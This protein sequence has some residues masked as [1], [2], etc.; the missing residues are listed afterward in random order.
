MRSNHPMLTGLRSRRRAAFEAHRVEARSTGVGRGALVTPRSMVT[1]LHRHQSFW[2][3]QVN[4]V[5]RIALVREVVNVGRARNDRI[6]SKNQT[7][8][9]GNGHDRIESR[10]LREQGPV[11]EILRLADPSEALDTRTERIVERSRTIRELAESTV[12]RVIR[13]RQRIES[14]RDTSVVMRERSSI[15]ADVE[16]A[17]ERTATARAGTEAGRADHAQQHAD[18]QPGVPALPDLD[19]LTEQ[20]VRRI[21][22]RL[23]AHQERMGTRFS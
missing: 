10:V 14:R 21:D 1:H 23:I 11:R 6:G 9:P 19:R 3:Q 13:R 20:I 18:V 12:E 22:D 15:A 16:R 7:A 5:F 17:L 4:P 8:I 2:R